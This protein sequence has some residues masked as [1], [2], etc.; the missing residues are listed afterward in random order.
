MGARV[1]VL[2]GRLLVRLG[3]QEESFLLALAIL[4]GIVTAWAAVGFHELI[5]VIRNWLYSGIGPRTD[6]FGRGIDRKSVV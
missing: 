4:I 3:F 6:L 1:R 2:V 5:V